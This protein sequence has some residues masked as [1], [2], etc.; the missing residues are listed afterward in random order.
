MHSSRII[1]INYIG[2]LVHS[3]MQQLV[4]F[5]FALYTVIHSSRVFAILI[6]LNKSYVDIKPS[7]LITLIHHRKFCLK[8]QA[9]FIY[10]YIK[11]SH[12]FIFFVFFVRSM[13]Q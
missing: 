10:T 8:A 9:K 12:T 13:L 5:V 11:V 1:Q 4:L 6:C 2:T 3:L 7:T